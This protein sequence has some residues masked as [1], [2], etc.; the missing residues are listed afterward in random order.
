MLACF[1]LLSCSEAEAVNTIESGATVCMAGCLGGCVGQP[2]LLNERFG[3][4]I[5]LLSSGCIRH[6]A[7]GLQLAMGA[8][9]LHHARAPR[10]TCWG[11]LIAS[12][13]SY[14]RSP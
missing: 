4:Y 6:L 2:P 11:P 14:L 5:R 7:S 3:I 12:A 13:V 9:H 10:Y 1:A 8:P